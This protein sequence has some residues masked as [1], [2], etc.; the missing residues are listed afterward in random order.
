M[1]DL[2]II[3]EL[4]RKRHNLLINLTHAFDNGAYVSDNDIERVYEIDEE[5]RKKWG[6]YQMSDAHVYSY[7][8]GRLL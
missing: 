1:I 5:L 7:K 4:R 8:K 3:N 2:T 6:K